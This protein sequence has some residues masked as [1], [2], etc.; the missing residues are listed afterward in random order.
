MFYLFNFHEFP[1]V[2]D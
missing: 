1:F 2:L